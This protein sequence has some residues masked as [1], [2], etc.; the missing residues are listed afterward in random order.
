M[1]F[2]VH[3]AMCHRPALEANTLEIPRWETSCYSLSPQHRID[4]LFGWIRF[5]DHKLPSASNPSKNLAASM[6]IYYMI[7]PGLPFLVALYL[8]AITSR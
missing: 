2:D 8:V 7:L 6:P 4:A 3:A 1:T 5:N